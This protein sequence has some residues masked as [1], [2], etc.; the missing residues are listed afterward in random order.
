MLEKTSLIKTVGL[1]VSALVAACLLQSCVT[2]T[3]G[4]F[5]VDSTPREQL[6]DYIRL[7][8]AYYEANDMS[9]A[10]VHI[11]N[12]LAIDR[13]SSG[14][15]TV[16][17]LVLQQEGDLELAEQNFRQAISYDGSN[18]R[19]R[20]N[21]AAMLFS[22]ARYEEAFD[23]LATVSSD[24]TYEGRDIAFENLGRSAMRLSRYGEAETAFERALQLNGNLYLSALQ[25]AQIRIYGE[26]WEAARSSYQRYLTT[27]QFYN[28]P[29]S[30]QSLWVGIQLEKHF[31]NDEELENYA[32]M[33]RTLF[34]DS[35]EYQMYNRLVNDN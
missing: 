34:A 31:R 28:I 26:N 35:A 14:A 18:S 32:L 19:A 3:T 33:L 9:R 8:S 10:R 30:P 13:R 1:W 11:N 12:A 4:G 25:L 6:E 24:T 7:A 5:T 23:Q 20:N 22:Q 15:Y 27:S 21:Y 2:T 29:H 16:Q 17:A